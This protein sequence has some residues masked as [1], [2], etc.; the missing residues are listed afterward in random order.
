MAN[1]ILTVCCAPVLQILTKGW[2]DCLMFHGV[3]KDTM[4]E[5]SKDE[6]IK[7]NFLDH[8]IKKLLLTE[9]DIDCSAV[10]THVFR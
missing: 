4:E 8:N 2:Q 1:S 10:F 7:K 5:M 3:E 9:W 6:E